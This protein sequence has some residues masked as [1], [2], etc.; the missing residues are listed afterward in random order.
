MGGR[1]LALTR[2]PPAQ[3]VYRLLVRLLTLPLLAWLWW[4]GRQESAYRERLGERLGLIDPEPASTDG[5]L[6][7]AASVG[8]VQAIRPLMESLAAHWPPHAITVS[9]QTPTGAATLREHWGQRIQHLYAPIDTP[10]ACAR[11]L[12]R[13]QPR[14]LVLVERELWPELL[15]QCRARDIPVVLINARLSQRSALGYQRWRALMQP[16]WQQLRLVCA[17]DGPTMDRLQQL[18]VPGERLVHTGNLKFDL[19]DT[20]ATDAP[21]AWPQNGPV[22]V[23]G[24]THEAEEA[25]LLDAWPRFVLRHPGALL[26]L[27]PR[28]PQRFDA[29]S[30]DL[31]QRGIGHAR[32]SRGEEPDND[33]R[34][35]LGDTMGELARW[36][37]LASVCFIGGS[38]QPIGGHNALEAMAE[39]RPVLFGP[40][41]HNFESLY[42]QVLE[43]DAGQQVH[44]AAELFDV[45]DRWLGD[46]DKL[47]AR[48]QRGRA[49]VESQRGAT[50]RTLASWDTH[51][52]DLLSQAP[53][54]VARVHLP[55]QSLWMAPDRLPSISPDDFD[56]ARHQT[57]SIATGSGRAQALRLHLH[58]TEAVLRHYRRGGLVAR[59]NPDRYWGRRVA[60]SRAMAEFS[61]LRWMVAR[62]LPVPRPLAARRAGGAWRYRADILVEWLPNTR[63]LAQVLDER[64]ASAAEWA[65]IGRSIRRMHDEQVCHTDLN[66][67]NLLL[68]SHESAWIVDFDKCSRRAGTEWKQGNLERLLRSLRK[69][70]VRRPGFHWQEAAWK[71]LIKAY[72][73]PA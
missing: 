61:L 30:Q 56:P 34:V 68:D 19:P 14:L 67:H 5:I 15:L 40:H 16:V 6:I 7:Q 44:S 35:W 39:G 64:P 32:R 57:R 9:T 48:G 53:A 46:P 11:F 17:A 12:D 50:A 2:V 65:A 26:I 28:H 22:I 52:P 54:P 20:A 41:T 18:G 70:A 25:Q 47:M 72:S 58:G 31:L 62:G 3:R 4:R 43:V 1:A 21:P 13:L 69:E 29:V 45:L 24:S 51:L 71:D 59:F 33:R 37:R 27:V 10:G 66:C 63:N 38:L 73:A 8:E 36:Y 23:A 42:Q 49:F 55:G 60:S